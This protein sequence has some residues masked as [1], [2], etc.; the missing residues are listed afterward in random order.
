[1]TDVQTLYDEDFVAWSKR[2]AKALRAA[3]GTATNQGLDWE[4]LA[5]EIEDLGKSVRRELRSQLTRIIH[6]LLKLQHSPATDP[7]RGWRSSIREVRSEVATLLNENPSLRG[8]LV[9]FAGEQLPEAI[10][11]ATADLEDYGEID[12]AARAR[13]AGTSY[14]P[15]EILDAWFPPSPTHRSGTGE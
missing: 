10:K 5:E 3:A 11:L 4:N 2:Q 1:M 6:H 9:R 8:E 13:L 15:G 14:T 12:P 7:R